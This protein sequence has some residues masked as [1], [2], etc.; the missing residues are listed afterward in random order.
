MGSEVYKDPS[1]K[2]MDHLK[3]RPR[4]AWKNIKL[5]TLRDLSHSMPSRLQ[6]VIKNKMGGGG[7]ALRIYYIEI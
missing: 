4:Q 5:S 1:P 6:N 3:R 7:G 2:N